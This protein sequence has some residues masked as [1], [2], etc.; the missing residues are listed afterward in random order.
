MDSVWLLEYTGGSYDDYFSE[1]LGVFSSLEKAK[2][3]RPTA[4]WD[5]P[6][7]TKEVWFSDYTHD[8][9]FII[10]LMPLDKI[11]SAHCGSLVKES[12]KDGNS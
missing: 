4:L 9:Y 6:D 1:V 5:K 12:W 7:E 2:Q 8:E 11:H 3:A 10:S